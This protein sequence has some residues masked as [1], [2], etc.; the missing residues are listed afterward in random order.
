MA[1]PRTIANAVSAARSFRPRTPLSA[2]R[3]I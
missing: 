3:I 2:T 1:T